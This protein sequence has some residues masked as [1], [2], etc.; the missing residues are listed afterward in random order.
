MAIPALNLRDVEPVQNAMMTSFDG[1]LQKIRHR[2]VPDR[3]GKKTP[4]LT[5]SK[6]MQMMLKKNA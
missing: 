2:F 6:K 1:L 5:T 3:D 4:T